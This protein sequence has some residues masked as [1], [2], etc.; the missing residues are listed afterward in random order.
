MSAAAGA[1][2]S[3]LARLAV[4]RC[5]P[6]PRAPASAHCAHMQPLTAPLATPRLRLALRSPR[7]ADAASRAS[8]VR[9][10]DDAPMPGRRLAPLCTSPA[11]TADTAAEPM[12][13]HERRRARLS[14][15]AEA[16]T[17]PVVVADDTGTPW[18]QA[19]AQYGKGSLRT[20]AMAGERSAALV[21]ACRR[22]DNCAPH[23]TVSPCVVPRHLHLPRSP[24]VHC[25][26]RCWQW[27][28]WCCCPT[29]WCNTRS[30]TG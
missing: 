23:N 9:V 16:R 2:A 27:A 29:S 15:A 6:L 11:D 17:R 21:Q 30:T 18:R 19:P 7:A 28:R 3:Q 26:G 8:G 25:S 5:T 13:R 12:R 22:S 20:E 24:P 10:T 4:S 1:A 14:T